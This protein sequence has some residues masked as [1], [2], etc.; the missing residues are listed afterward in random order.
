MDIS[1]MRVAGDLYGPWENAEMP[2][3]SWCRAIETKSA[4]DVDWAGRGLQ[5]AGDVAADIVASLPRNSGFARLEVCLLILLFLS[6]D[7]FF[8][9]FPLF[10]L[11]FGLSRP[12]PPW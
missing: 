8:L 4:V 9:L 5:F 1:F 6:L 3:S 2:V 10:L 7:Y 11:S 12:T